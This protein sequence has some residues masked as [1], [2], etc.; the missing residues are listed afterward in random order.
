MDGVSAMSVGTGLWAAAFAVLLLTGTRFADSNG[1]WLWACLA[2]FGI[3]LLGMV[4]T[5]RRAAVYRAHARRQ[6][7]AAGQ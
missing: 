1:W 2:G 7:G 5:R 4:F 6:R 3:G